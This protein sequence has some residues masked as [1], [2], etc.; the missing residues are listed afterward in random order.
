[1]TNIK[2]LRDDDTEQALISIEEH[3]KLLI[4]IQKLNKEIKRLK[5]D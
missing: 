3:K 5:N 4:R 2:I 1:M